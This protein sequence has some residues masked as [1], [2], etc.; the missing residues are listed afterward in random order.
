MFSFDARWIKFDYKP[1][2]E[3]TLDIDTLDELIAV[4]VTATDAHD[5]EAMC[6]FLVKTEGEFR[7]HSSEL[8]IF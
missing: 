4:T 6:T 2:A 8:I 3:V 5:T 7:V 1:S